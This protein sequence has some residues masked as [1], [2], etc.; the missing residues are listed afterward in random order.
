MTAI[1]NVLK[2][3]FLVLPLLFLGAIFA[4]SVSAE[5]TTEIYDNIIEHFELDSS[6]YSYCGYIDSYWVTFYGDIKSGRVYFVADDALEFQDVTLVQ[7]GCTFNLADLYTYENYTRINDMEH[8][9]GDETFIYN[10]FGS[11]GV[12]FSSPFFWNMNASP[13]T[14]IN[15][16][17][18]DAQECG[19]PTEIVQYID[20]NQTLPPVDTTEQT[21]SD[22]MLQEYLHNNGFGVDNF[23]AW[24]IA[25][26]TQPI[27][28]PL[29]FTEPSNYNGDIWVKCTPFTPYLDK[30][31][32]IVRDDVS[33]IDY[34]GYKISIKYDFEATDVSL[35]A[36]TDSDFV[37]E[38]S[39][40]PS[41][42]VSDTPHGDHPSPFNNEHGYYTIQDVS[43][44]GD[45]CTVNNSQ[46]QRTQL[47]CIW[48]F[49]PLPAAA[50]PRL[51]PLY[52]GLNVVT[53]DTNGNVV[54]SNDSNDYRQFVTNY[55]QRAISGLTGTI[56]GRT[57]FTGD[58]RGDN[59]DTSFNYQNG[60]TF[61]DNNV[62]NL[63]AN[64]FSMGNGFVLS[65][66]IGVMSIAL[67]AYVLFGKH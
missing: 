35:Y 65:A 37:Q 60:F 17:Y 16:N 1:S 21:Y 10:H 12:G 19:I 29:S 47:Y 18:A 66:A 22:L 49:N 53:T 2:S 43:Y 6:D 40:Y 52:V 15:A 4:P 33:L 23:T 24:L 13:N 67:A 61:S 32:P 59:I 7:G 39:A 9:D 25:P 27:Q 45:L 48:E 57:S 38:L 8:P 44:W 62:T 30:F 3:K 11:D 36:V 56:N 50:I 26:S 42:N 55:N 31:M 34:A 51:V 20:Y 58:W 5:D 54:I 46:N 41:I 64:V 63:F 28:I 14:S